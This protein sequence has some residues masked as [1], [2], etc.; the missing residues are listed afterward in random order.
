M[1][2]QRD[3]R[4]LVWAG[5]QG[6]DNVLV[7]NHRA[8]YVTRLKVK[9]V[10]KLHKSFD[11]G[12]EPEEALEQYR[13]IPLER[14]VAIEYQHSAIYRIAM[15]SILHTRKGNTKRTEVAFT[16]PAEREAFKVELQARLPPCETTESI[17]NPAI[18][19]LKY[20]P[21]FVGIAFATAFLSYWEWKGA[22]SWFFGSLIL[23]FGAAGCLL[24]V[25]MAV[26]ELKRPPLKVTYE[27]HKEPE[28]D[29]DEDEEGEAADADA[30]NA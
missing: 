30:D 12:E 5:L 7:L 18:T 9:D 10:P 27:P 1:G 28:P 17:Q 16:L 24:T 4:P 15:L 29:M 25:G 6:K 13:R 8:V 3:D 20:L 21:Y 26:R 2:K 22:D 23:L 11:T 14:I 19:I